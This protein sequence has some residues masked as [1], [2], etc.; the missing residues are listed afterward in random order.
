[1][2]EWVENK[3]ENKGF[4]NKMFEGWKSLVYDNNRNFS[5][6]SKSMIESAQKAT[7]ELELEF[8]GA[9]EEAAIKIFNYSRV[10]SFLF[11]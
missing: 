7:K 10:V 2:N 9:E 4:L 6:I 11:F 3:L 5:E 8:D 1:M